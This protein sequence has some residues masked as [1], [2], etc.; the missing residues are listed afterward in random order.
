LC[1]IFGNGLLSLKVESGQLIEEMMTH[2]YVQSDIGIIGFWSI[3]G[4][5]PLIVIYTVIFKILYRKFYPFY[6][7]AM[8]A[9]ILLVPICFSFNRFDSLLFIF[10]F[11]LFAYHTKNHKSMEVQNFRRKFTT[12][13]T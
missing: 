7:K 11:Y 6:I 13:Y 8:A 5:L 10:L 1:D 9:H 4:I 3:Y 12:S 2:G